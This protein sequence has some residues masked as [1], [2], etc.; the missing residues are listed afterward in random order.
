MVQNLDVLNLESFFLLN[1]PLRIT[2]QGIGSSVCLPMLVIDPEV[3]TKKLFGSADLS[4]AQTL[5][6]YEPTEV[7]VVS[8]Y[9]HLML[10]PF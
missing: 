9:K 5:C 6:V 4:G 7:F 10:R 8:K 3:V 2:K 1:N